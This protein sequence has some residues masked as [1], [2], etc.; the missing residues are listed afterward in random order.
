MLTGTGNSLGPVIGFVSGVIM[1]MHFTDILT[2]FLMGGVGAAGGYA[3]TQ[4]LK[5]LIQKLKPKNKDENNTP[6]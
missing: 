4:G 5:Y 2:T 1:N 6:R 3:F